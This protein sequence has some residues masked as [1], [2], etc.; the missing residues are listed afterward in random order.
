MELGL[1]VQQL[2]NTLEC[3]QT[4]LD[5]GQTA[6]LLNTKQLL[7]VKEFILSV[8]KVLPTEETK[9]RLLFT[10]VSVLQNKRTISNDNKFL[11]CLSTQT[12]GLL[13]TLA[14]D[15]TLNDATCLNS[16]TASIKASFRRLWLPAKTDYVV[17]D[18]SGCSGSLVKTIQNSWFSTTLISPQN[19]SLQ[20][21]YLPYFKS[22][23]AVGTVEGTTLLRSRKIRLQLTSLQIKALKPHIDNYRYTKNRAI[24][25]LN[26]LSG[27]GGYK[28]TAENEIWRRRTKEKNMCK[29]EKKSKVCGKESCLKHNEN[30]EKENTK[31]LDSKYYMSDWDYRDINVPIEA[32]CRTPWLLDTPSSIRRH[33]SNTAC[34]NRHSMFTNLKNGNIKRFK[35]RF[36]SKRKKEWSLGGIEKRT[37]T[38]LDSRRVNIFPSLGF[39]TFKATQDLPES[40]NHDCMLHFDGKY[41]YLIIPEDKIVKNDRHRNLCISGDPGV[42]S[43][44]TMYDPVNETVF[45]IGSG[46]S[47]KMHQ[48]LL[49]LDKMISSSTKENCKTKKVLKKKITTTRKRIQDLQSELHWKTSN[50]LCKNYAEVIIPHF[51]SKE[52]SKKTKERKISNRTVRD[53]MVLGHCKFLERLKTK[54][55]E[56][57]TTVTIVDEI[58]TT[59]RCGNCNHLQHNVRDKKEWKC[60]GCKRIMLRDASAGRNIFRKVLDLGREWRDT[61]SPTRVTPSSLFVNND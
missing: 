14:Q 12:L 10:F 8:L 19:K 28:K 23:H 5:D 4:P 25:L 55:K 42:R 9:R 52:M 22:L 16:W 6:I 20:K 50:W 34:E 43:F 59:K 58:N 46:A 39:G 24:S 17:S 51:G 49:K 61:A 33:A 45:D 54:A 60:S 44:L 15:S 1:E 18:T 41:H 57:N 27:G 26:E 13:K 35:Q 56:Y 7:V 47:T 53:M 32:N 29:Y 21:T 31:K 40:V 37:V 11:H 36:I 3:M 30:Y 38:I 2:H 48:Q